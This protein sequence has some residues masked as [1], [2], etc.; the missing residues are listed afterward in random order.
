MSI[1]PNAVNVHE[2]A[3][4]DVRIIPWVN[5]LVLSFLAMML[6]MLRRMWMQ[7][8]ERMI[9][10]AMAEVGETWDAVDAKADAAR[11][12]AAGFFGRIGA[13]IATW[14]GKPRA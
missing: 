3:G 13:W 12:R 7:F 11:G 1:Y 2:V 4:P 8:R 14:R 9:E 6:F 5:I 10:P